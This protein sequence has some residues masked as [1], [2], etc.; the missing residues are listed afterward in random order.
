MTAKEEIDFI[1]SLV[2]KQ[3]EDFTTKMFGSL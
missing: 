1:H 2:R 3:I